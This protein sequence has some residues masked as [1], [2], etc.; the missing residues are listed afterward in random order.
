MTDRKAKLGSQFETFLRQYG[1]TSRRGGFDPN[2]RKYDRK[3]ERLY[4]RMRPEDVAEI[5]EESDDDQT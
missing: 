2:D 5:F 1:R 3:V 4:K